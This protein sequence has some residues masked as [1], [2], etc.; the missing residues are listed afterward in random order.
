MM[1]HCPQCPDRDFANTK[2][3]MDHQRFSNRWH[4]FCKICDKAFT[5]VSRRTF[6]E[7]MRRHR[8]A[9]AEFKCTTCSRGFATVRA[10][11]EH[12]R[13]SPRHPNC[14]VRSCGKGFRNSWDCEEHVKQK[15]PT[16][17]CPCGEQHFTEER[18]VHFQVSP[19][20]VVC[21]I[22]NAGFAG[23]GAL[24]EHKNVAHKNSWCERCKR[25]FSDQDEL[26]HHYLTS[27]THPTC[28]ICCLGFADHDVFRQHIVVNHSPATPTLVKS[29]ENP[30]NKGDVQN[31]SSP[32]TQDTGIPTPSNAEATRWKCNSR[33]S[34]L[35][36]SSPIV[37]SLWDSSTPVKNPIR[38]W[39]ED[40]ESPIPK[41]DTED[42]SMVSMVEKLIRESEPEPEFELE[43]PQMIYDS[44]RSPTT[45]TG[46]TKP[47]SL[48]LTTN[49][50]ES[51]S[52]TVFDPFGPSTCTTPS[53][54]TSS[55]LGLAVLPSVSPVAS[56][57]S[58]ITMI[59][60]SS[61]RHKSTS[62]SPLSVSP[63]KQA[64][65]FPAPRRGSTSSVETRVEIIPDPDCHDTISQFIASPKRW[66]LF[67][68]AIGALTSPAG[69]QK[70]HMGPTTAISLDT[71]VDTVLCS[72]PSPDSSG[73]EPELVPLSAVP[74]SPDLS[75]ISF[76]TT[77][78]LAME[79]ELE[80]PGPLP[81]QKGARRTSRR[82]QKSVIYCRLCGRD[83]CDGCTA[84]LCG[85]VYCYGCITE[86]LIKTS[87]CPTCSTP[88]LL[89]C[90]VRLDLS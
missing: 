89:Y 62:F 42:R 77:D 88:T 18:E 1:V 43:V 6:E 46:P 12:F 72:Q 85:H 39:E 53:P 82:S 31:T 26:L 75:S 40:P 38:V 2:A 65:Y 9:D 10:L 49:F 5:S 8:E 47:I 23:A 20:H 68:D 73:S 48:C 57:P 15:H 76:S 13:Q 45:F 32:L 34:N 19:N 63:L 64:T 59:E 14:P 29:V 51:S 50:N 56:T 21:P 16:S 30:P 79:R 17:D 84:T 3:F 71:E 54:D 4:P 86:H 37:R 55:P 28:E 90:L 80:S 25:Q 52:C 61:K 22:C 66:R 44:A 60:G 36:I 83:P 87:R 27:V 7:H 41:D 78:M 24:F 58:D 81:L 74:T 35:D 67:D 11:E 69:T 70:H 33:A